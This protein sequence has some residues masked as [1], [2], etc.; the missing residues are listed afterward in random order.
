MRPLELT[1]EGF[2]CFRDK[3]VLDLSTL[4]VFGI[5]GA[6][7]AGKSSLLDAI[8]FALFG[9]VVRVGRSCTSL[10]S[11]GRDAMSVVLAF[12][13]GEK[14]YRVARR[15]RRGAAT[16][17]VLEDDEA[18]LASKVRDVDAK[19]ESLVG[20]P[21]E[22]FT[23][24]VVLPQGQFAKFLSSTGAART[25][26]LRNLL[27]LEIYD[28]M[29]RRAEEK[30]KE[31]DQRLRILD[32]QRV[33]LFGH[34]S[35]ARLDELAALVDE[36]A[37][38][39]AAL[40]REA[41][42]RTTALQE[43]Q[44]DHQRTVD[45]RATEGDVVR[46]RAAVDAGAETRAWLSRAAAAEPLRAAIAELDER[47]RAL[48]A[49]T[50]SHARLTSALAAA[51][52][53]ERSAREALDRATT[54]SADL[55]ALEKNIADLDRVVDVA[56]ALAADRGALL[57]ARRALKDAEKAEAARV[58]SERER[59]RA[60]DA[61]R[62]TE[63]SAR[64]RLADAERTRAS[65]AAL[66]PLVDDAR[67]I[68]DLERIVA[69]LETRGREVTH[70]IEALIA[71]AEKDRAAADEA[72]RSLAE[73]K[74]RADEA[75]VERERAIHDGHAD[76]LRERLVKGEACPVCDHPVES[77]PKKTKKKPKKAAVDVAA[78]DAR[79][80]DW[81]AA[82]ATQRARVEATDAAIVEGRA[83]LDRTQ[84]AVAEARPA[85]EARRTALFGALPE[86]ARGTTTPETVATWLVSTAADLRKG[87][88]TYEAARSDVEAAANAARRLGDQLDEARGGAAERA[89][90]IADRRAKVAHLEA[91]IADAARRVAA[92]TDAEDPAAERDECA[93][94]REALVE[95]LATQTRAHAKAH[96]E[97]SAAKAV[98]AESDREAAA[99]RASI[100][101]GS[102]T[103]EGASLDAGF[104]SSD[105]L[106]AALRTPADVDAARR[107]LE[108]AESA[109]GQA[110]ARAVELATALGDVRISDADLSRARD[111]AR[112]SADA[113]DQ[114][115]RVHATREQ[116]LRQ[117]RVDLE[118][119]QS[120]DDDRASAAAEKAIFTELAGDLG[121]ANFQQHLQ[122][123]VVRELT[124]QASHRLDRLS[125]GR[126]RLVVE[127]DEFWV[128]DRENA[129]A[130]RPAA[131]LSGGE[132]FLA[133]LALALALSDQIQQAAGAVR[134]ESLFIDEGFGTLDAEALDVAADAVEALEEGGRM[135]GIIS[136]LPELNQR[137]HAE[138]VVERRPS[139]SSVI[140]TR[141]H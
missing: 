73:A 34:A 107:A 98:V 35:P 117:L 122:A 15:L 95:A 30:R 49:R 96:A 121:T 56:R 58:E 65:V 83:D 127:D 94:R 85:L 118:R 88:A 2:T 24:A 104:G 44:R 129:N 27:G 13:I 136:H 66:E 53:A 61:A 123:S 18:A 5:S 32:D 76:A 87:R 116:E 91:A 38:R 131:T 115:I 16:T 140:R 43:T 80:E 97:L 11:L 41:D 59:V 141:L 110:E 28:R 36:D 82:V 113:R 20:M 137:L 130:S 31:A 133:S 64:A 29:R 55:P 132:T 103:L 93:T 67:A 112:A 10:I 108:R 60:L 3:T 119:A 90:L 45:L 92:V 81:R 102:T 23:Q 42:E 40:S 111:A 17:A 6:T 124:E 62:A 47:S 139:G 50:K 57:G 48:A 8:T 134:L 74:S 72:S 68:S 70:R 138:L 100:E 12:R 54:R 1:M 69:G 46:L 7:G 77:L 135:V 105:E 109:L 71:Q 39:I 21:F 126:Y 26:I 99:L 37:A 114:A 89:A 14:S 86:E 19:I 128:V 4:E 51:T 84:S 9:R 101:R 79:V 52:D 33:R 63:A 106:K 25:E 75:R 22:T 125:R 78:L 120:H